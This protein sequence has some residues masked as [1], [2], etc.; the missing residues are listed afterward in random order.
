[1]PRRSAASARTGEYPGTFLYQNLIMGTHSSRPRGS[2]A[3]KNLCS[4]DDLLV[5]QIHARSLQGMRSLERLSRR[6][7]RPLR[8]GQEAAHRPT[9]AYRQEFGF[10]GA[11]VLIVNLYGPGDNFDLESSH[12]IPALIRK[13]VEAKERGDKVLPVW[14]TGRP[15]RE[16]LYAEDAAE[17]IVRAAEVLETPDPVNIGS[18]KEIA[19][20][21]LRGSSRRRPASVVN[22][23]SIQTCP[24]DSPA[25]PRRDAGEGTPRLHRQDEP[26][27]WSGEHSRLVSCLP[28]G[29]CGRMIGKDEDPLTSMVSRS[30]AIVRAARREP[31]G[32]GKPPAGSRRAARQ[33]PNRTHG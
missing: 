27:R 19:I 4:G 7:E 16:F 23:S 31:A 18:G 20:G 14:G 5:S 22:S 10:N 6:N 28:Q 30:N 33:N 17:G 29:N 1:M 21:E 15:T 9:Q 2:R 11:N 8:P 25:L 12:V 3:S 13:C 32:G 26:G 24:T